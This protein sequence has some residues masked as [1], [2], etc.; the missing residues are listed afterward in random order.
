MPTVQELIQLLEARNQTIAER[1]SRISELESELDK[2]QQEIVFLKRS[3]FGRKSEKAKVPEASSLPLFPDFDP[4]IE[5]IDNTSLNV[6]PDE[7]IDAIEE[8]SRQRREREK[9]KKKNRQKKKE[10]LHVYLLMPIWS[11]LSPKFTRKVMMM[12]R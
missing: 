11:V 5:V 6:K 9:A 7:V 3:L 10:G 12:K 4:G 8:E 1:D 2:K